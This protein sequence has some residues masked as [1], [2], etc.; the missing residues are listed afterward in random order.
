MI[1]LTDY[2][3][4]EGEPY[5]LVADLTA[6][7]TAAEGAAIHEGPGYAALRDG[8]TVTWFDKLDRPVRRKGAVTLA[9]P[10]SFVDYLTRYA[11]DDTLLYADIDTA[12]ITAVLN[13]HPETGDVAADNVLAGWRDNTA[14]MRLRPAEDWS[15]IVNNSGQ[16]L[17]QQRFAELM[18]EL[19]HTVS[20]PDSATML[21]V[22]STLNVKQNID[23]GS[24]VRTQSGDV[25]FRFEQTSDARAGRGDN[26]VEIPTVVAFLTN[27]WVGTEPV[28]ITARLRFRASGD[29][30][31]M[32]YKLIRYAE[33]LENAFRDIVVAINERG[34]VPPAVYGTANV[35]TSRW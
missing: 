8:S 22:A 19:A 24:R 17:P 23:F 27:P 28:N 29:G 31:V 20:Q 34:I 5:A 6:R 18:E 25:E 7:L 9:D 2:N 10:D 14:T 32:G 12:T 4:N 21:E 16:F 26:R 3:A 35:S 13:D 30:C 33:V 15:T 11:T 1:D